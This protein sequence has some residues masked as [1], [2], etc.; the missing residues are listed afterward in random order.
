VPADDLTG[1]RAYQGHPLAGSPAGRLQDAA[2]QVLAAGNL[3][4]CP[5]PDQPPWWY[6][7][8]GAL[9]CGDCTRALLE[10]A[11]DSRPGCH[12]CG[13]P[14]TAVAAWMLG[15]VPCL[16]HLCDECHGTGLVPLTF[17]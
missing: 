8:A 1:V 4:R 11:D 9:T 13:T 15:D 5:H 10:A 7:P 3:P 16:G 2:A 14:A 17:N 6:L 12:I